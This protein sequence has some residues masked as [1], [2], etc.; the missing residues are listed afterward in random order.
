[1][2]WDAIKHCFHVRFFTHK[3]FSD[4]VLAS[5]PAS[6]KELSWYPLP[7]VIKRFIAGLFHVPGVIDSLLIRGLNSLQSFRYYWDLTP[8]LQLTIMQNWTKFA[9]KEA[10]GKV[11]LYLKKNKKSTEPLF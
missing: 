11:R 5:V 6:G 7:I 2:R 4:R 3:K 1:M 8:S 10:T 9:F